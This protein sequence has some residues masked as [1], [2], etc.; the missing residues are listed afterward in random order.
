MA[1]ATDCAALGDAVAARGHSCGDVLH[2]LELD[3]QGRPVPYLSFT[4]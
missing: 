2:L 1:G 3:D 4:S